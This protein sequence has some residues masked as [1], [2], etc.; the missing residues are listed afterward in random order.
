MSP[1]YTTGIVLSGGGARGFSH[2]GVLQA[3]NEEGIYPDIISGVSAGAIAGVFYADGYTPHEILKFLSGKKGL[4]Y[5]GFIVPKD[6]LMDMNGLRKILEKYLTA[7]KFGDLKIPLVVAATDLNH[8]KITYFSNGN[9]IEVIIASSSIPVLFKPVLINNTQYLDGGIMDNFP[10][11]PLARKCKY[12][13]GS[14]ANP[15]GYS[16]KLNTMIDIAERTFH[17]SVASHIIEKRNRVDLFIDPVELQK[18]KILNPS[19]RNEIYT[20][21]YN[22][23]KKKL[24]TIKAGTKISQILSVHK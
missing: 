8:G 13:I 14:H 21:G 4:D 9:L 24:R 3:L 17:L 11:H 7:R 16:H 18:F 1:E 12:L 15:I 22:E 19:M 6:G 2:L 20:I 10:V 23:T 5:F